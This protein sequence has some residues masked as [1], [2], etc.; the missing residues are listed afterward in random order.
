MN[1]FLLALQE[2][3]APVLQKFKAKGW[4]YTVDFDYMAALSKK[5][6]MSCIGATSYA[7][8]TIYVSSA[9]ATLHEFGHFIDSIVNDST[10]W[11]KLYQ[12][13]A[14]ESILRDYAKTNSREYFADC[15]AYWITYSG[16]TKHMEFFR[17]TAP[18]TYAYMEELVVSNWG[19]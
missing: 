14:S 8:K 15:F 17:D 11:E 2:V 4:T 9:K 13:E 5:L 19:C 3:P 7:D 6:G 1:D 16:S 12:A 10:E 18:Q